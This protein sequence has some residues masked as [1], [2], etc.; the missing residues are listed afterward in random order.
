VF[1]T[2]TAP[3]HHQKNKIPEN[4]ESRNLGERELRVETSTGRGR[5][6]RKNR[7]LRKQLT[8]A[9]VLRRLGLTSRGPGAA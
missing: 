2:H 9:T 1:K 4:V 8:V 7:R 5:D 3:S 6:K